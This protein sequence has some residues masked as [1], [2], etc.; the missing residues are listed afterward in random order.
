MRANRSELRRRS[1]PRPLRSTGLQAARVLSTA[2]AHERYARPV[3]RLAPHHR[4]GPARASARAR[5]PTPSPSASKHLG[6]YRE[7]TWRD[8][9]DAGGAH[10]RAL[11]RS[12][13]RPGERVAIM[14]DASEEWMICDLAAQSLGAIVYGIYPT[15]SASEVEYQMRDGGAVIFIAE[16]QEYVDKIL[17]LAD[18]LPDSARH[19]RDR[20]FDR[21]V[22]LRA[23]QAAPL[24]RMLLAAGARP[25]CALARDAWPRALEPERSGLHRLHVRHDR[26]PEGR[27]RHPRQASRRHRQLVDALSD[28]RRE[29]APHRRLPAALPCARPR[30]RRDPAADVAPR[31]AF[32]RG[33]RRPRADPLRGGADRAVHRAALPAEIRRRRC[34]SASMQLV[35][36][37]ARALRARHAVRARACAPPLGRH[38][39]AARGGA[40][41]RWRA[42][43][44]SGRSSTSSASTS[45]S[46]SIS[47]GAPLPADTMALWQMYGVNVVEMYGQTETAGGIIAGQRG[48]FPRPG[49]VGTVAGRL[50]RDARRRRRDPGA[51]RRPVRGLLEQRRGDAAVV[52]GDGWLRTGDVGEWRDGNLRL[53]DRARDFIV[54]AGG[55]TMSPSFIENMLRASPYVAEAI[56]FG[57]GRKYLTALIEIDF[58]TV[59]DWARSHDV[60]YTGFTSLAQNRA[61]DGLIK[62]RDRQGQRASSRAS[63]RSRRSASCPRRSIPRRRASR[64]RRP[65]R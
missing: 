44:C 1:S 45:S 32:R 18:R 38:G 54:T 53:V 2:T 19:R 5:V 64:S 31:A 58:D 42:A 16:D 6:L 46:S 11:R 37:E 55:K 4:A 33:R 61:V 10:A 60:T 14:G 40:L 26:P 62:A 12:A 63:S 29:G 25:I 65:A 9:A 7:R 15:A 3:T 51:Q 39:A 57:H 41:S 56:V 50:G 17:P 28:A 59:A 23:P 30:R 36:A 35:A 49:D 21:H 47:G 48:P 20:R 27:A 22:R 13:S 24:S 8:Y 34:W 43:V 52:G